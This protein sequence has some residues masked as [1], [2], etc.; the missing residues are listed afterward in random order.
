MKTKVVNMTSNNGNKVP[1]QFIITVNGNTFFQSYSS[2]IAV[3]RETG[4]TELDEHY[5]DYSST[6][7]KYRNQF[8]RESKKETEEKIKNGTY[9]LCNL[10]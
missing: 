4:K 2:I 8:L 3:K 10:N 1:N 5:W 6:T 7:G 9:K